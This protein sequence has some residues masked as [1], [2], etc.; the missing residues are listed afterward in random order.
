MT[1]HNS[2]KNGWDFTAR[3]YSTQY[4]SIK[5]SIYVADVD[6]AIRQLTD[7]INSYK[8]VSTGVKQ[9]KGNVAEHWH[10]GTFNI[11]AALKESAHHAMAEESNK[12]ASVDISTNY[13]KNYSLKYYAD[14]KQS[15]NSQATDV[16][17]S[18]HKYLSGSKAKKPMSFQEYLDRYGYSNND[19]ELYMSIYKGQGRII[20]TEQLSE[21]HKYLDDSIIKES[22]KDAPHRI[23]K[24][25]N[26][27][28][29]KKHLTD[30]LSDGE[31]VE[32][33]PLTKDG[34]EE[35]AAS[36]KSGEFDPEKYG[37]TVD[38][39]I[40]SQYII[41]QAIKAGTSA[42]MIS[43]VLQLGPEL[44]KAIDY[45]IKNGE[46]SSEQIK[47]LGFTTLSA[48]AEGFLRGSIASVATI[49]CCT[50]KLG[51]TLKKADSNVI[52]AITV[53]T[54]DALKNSIAVAQGRISHREMGCALIRDITVS[55]G[56]LAGGLFGELLCAGVPMGYMLGSFVGSVI[57]SVTVDVA[58]SAVLSFCVESGFTCFGLVKQD[59]TLPEEIL[60]RM[61]IDTIKVSRINIKRTPLK[62]IQV[63]KIKVKRIQYETIDVIILR[64][65]V[66]GVNRVGYVLHD[67]L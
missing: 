12:H 43:L 6:N 52:A 65:G 36:A 24:A 30:R 61:G 53:I 66:I 48:G 40:E 35:I 13:G 14:A 5:S 33:H 1:E 41:N 2:V 34:A 17:Q 64:R 37:L 39:L 31:G 47:K 9:L 21:A 19:K 15:A 42:A 58:G 22:T 57:A 62:R 25:E 10:A 44:Y 3:F 51:V 11:E 49:A 50:G 46:I 29:T 45:L 63:S 59:Y 56:G 67:I 23:L 26:F 27:R 20:P 7:S 32:S 16:I 18:Y 8:G 54:L 55:A 60:N 28:E 4:S 38:E